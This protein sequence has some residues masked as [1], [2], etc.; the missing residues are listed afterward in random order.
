M[1]K[2]L[3]IILILIIHSFPTF[4]SSPNDKGVICKCVAYKDGKG[5]PYMYPIRGFFFSNNK[6][7]GSGF[8]RKKDTYKIF[9]SKKVNYYTS[10]KLINWYSKVDDMYLT[11]TLNRKTLELK[12]T[13]RDYS[14]KSKCELFNKLNYDNKIQNIK[15]SLQSEYNMKRKDNKI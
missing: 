6:V 5:C 14:F 2:I 7:I 8:N 3:T 10:E 15:N 9:Y 1:K 12:S 4:S 11:H 13:N